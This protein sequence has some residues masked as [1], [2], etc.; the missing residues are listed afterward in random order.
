MRIV[1]SNHLSV[2]DAAVGMCT[3]PVSFMA[4]ANLES[5]PVIRNAGRVFGMVYVDREKKE[6][7]TDRIRAAGRGERTWPLWIFPEGK[8]TA[9]DCLLGFR[10]GAFVEDCVVQ[11]V[12]IRWKHWLCPRGMTTI[13]WLSNCLPFYVYQLFCTPFYTAEINYL[14]SVELKR[15]K[16]TPEESA[17]SIQLQIANFLGTPAIKQTNREL[18]SKKSTIRS[19]CDA[20][21]RN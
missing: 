20:C 10:T 6:G 8:V 2:L 1:V 15:G 17:V 21:L 13:S 19:R 9:G 3:S 14:E 4:A 18:F 12:A 5:N 7:V 11:P 16:Q